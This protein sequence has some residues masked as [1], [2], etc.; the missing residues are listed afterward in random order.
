MWEAKDLDS[1]ELMRLLRAQFTEG[2]TK[3]CR[4]ILDEVEHRLRYGRSS[5]DHTTIV[6]PPVKL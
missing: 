2:P 6:P 5:G 1:Q 4:E 3:E